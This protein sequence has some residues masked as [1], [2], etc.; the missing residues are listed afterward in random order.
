MPMARNWMRELTAL[1][2]KVRRHDRE[3]ADLQYVT[4]ETSAVL[5][6]QKDRLRLLQLLGKNHSRGITRAERAIARMSRLVARRYAR[7]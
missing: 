6:D 1:D 2:K 3:I 5:R 7:K 4:S